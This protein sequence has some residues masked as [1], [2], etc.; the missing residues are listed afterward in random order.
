MS[1]SDVIAPS[2]PKVSVIL[3]AYNHAPFVAQAIEGVLM[4]RVS[5]P[6]ELIVA[7]D[8]STDGTREAV[9]E[10][11]ASHSDRIR[12][13]FPEANLGANEMFLRALA[14]ARGEYVAFLEGDDYWTSPHK[15][16]RQVDALEANPGWAG[17]FHRAALVYGEAGHP[18]SNGHTIPGFGGADVGL[19]ELVGGL[20]F[21]PGPS[22]M[23]RRSCMERLPSLEGVLWSDWLI[24][25]AV[26]QHGSLGF[27]DEVLAAYRMHPSGIF[28]GLDRT[29]QLEEDLRFYSRLAA[30]LPA[31]EALIEECVANRHC[32]LAV[33][34]A[35]LPYDAPLLVVEPWDDLPLYF[36]G[37]LA[38]RFPA[39]GSAEGEVPAQAFDRVCEELAGLPGA[40][41][42]ARPKEPPLE[43][44]GEQDVYL[45][46]PR[47]A[48]AW[49]E[50]QP[51]LA[52]RLEE[53]AT[54]VVDGDSCDIYRMACDGAPS[55]SQDPSAE[56]D[57]GALEVVAVEV[58]DP[59]PSGLG[60]WVDVP[61]PGE[62]RAAHAIYVIGWALGDEDPVDSVAF[63]HEGE[64]ICRAGLGVRRPDLASAF[65]DRPDAEYAGFH[66]IVNV[67]G[68]PGPELAVE[69][70][71]ETKSGLRLELATLRLRCGV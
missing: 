67:A 63:E 18:H 7:D 62:R 30:E 64:V 34:A 39:P 6:F 26:A 3:Q 8:A 70:F 66:T 58:A 31:H 42:D 11:A 60:G 50:G 43:P 71:A 16:A 36:N 59:L 69:L 20:C 23:H 13:V 9:L 5:F 65:P 68:D 29:A 32:Q 1:S 38:H 57:G 4:Q 24:H 55:R 25:I 19:D 53:R 40:V 15:L 27:L 49:L 10:Y 35:R 14:E 21:L 33:E 22:W 54:K 56:P 44:D 28:N 2:A 48:R 41:P 51:Q 37:R 46:V 47:R 61:Q 17:C 52:G 12:P 45:L